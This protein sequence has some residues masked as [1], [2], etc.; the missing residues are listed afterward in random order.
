MVIDNPE[1]RFIYWWGR[2]INVATPY[3]ITS[4]NEAGLFALNQS[5]GRITVADSV[6]LDYETLGGSYQLEVEVTDEN[7][8]TYTKQVS[9][10][11]ADVN[12]APSLNDFSL[13]VVE[14]SDQGTV[15][16]S[17]AGNDPE[18]DRLYYRIVGGN[19]L[20]LFDI[21]PL[22][23]DITVGPNTTWLDHEKLNALSFHPFVSTSY[24]LE[25]EV[26]DSTGNSDIGVVTIDITNGN[27]PVRLDDHTFFL[28][29]LGV[30]S[31]KVIGNISEAI[32]DTSDN[33]NY[34]FSIINQPSIS[35]IDIFD[36]DATTGEVRI[37]SGLNPLDLENWLLQLDGGLEI[38][39]G[40]DDGRFYDEA[41]V[42][43]AKS[44]F[45]DIF[46]RDGINNIFAVSNI[47]ADLLNTR[48]TKPSFADLDEDGDLDALIG[49]KEL[50]YEWVKTSEN[51]GDFLL[52]DSGITL[53]E[54]GNYAAPASVDL[55]GDGDLDIVVGGGQ[56]ALHYFQNDGNGNFIKQ[57]GIL[58]PFRGI[59]VG[60]NA[61]PAFA[62]VDVMVMQMPL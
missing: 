28:H 19:Q 25:I 37:N 51:N 59:Y 43:L 49:S 47:L 11:I 57:S 13:S 30:Q 5:T 26:T 4:G 40:V 58:N 8:L 12:E 27:D 60:G 48:N 1:T 9:I 62:D 34:T 18:D 53:D 2:K 23:G 56:G 22:T 50:G 35:N 6:N 41:M 33:N 52:P 46:G 45:K 61:I 44:R 31:G 39:I 32:N 7:G 15:L 42:T 3:E 17:V 16:G 10:A 20:S 29:H 38:T 55:D 21:D 36:I 14:H 24:N 54:Y